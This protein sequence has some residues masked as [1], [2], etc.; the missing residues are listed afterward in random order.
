MYLGLDLGTS[1]LKVLLL[2]DDHRIVGVAGA[3]LTVSRPHPLW[4]E[5]S[6]SQ[7]WSALEQVMAALRAAHPDELAAV[8][9]EFSAAAALPPA[10]VAAC[11]DWPADVDAAP[12]AVLALVAD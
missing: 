6:P 5:Q 4:S 8:R 1:E 11:E 12:A 3:A 9:A 10:A 2:T 7:W